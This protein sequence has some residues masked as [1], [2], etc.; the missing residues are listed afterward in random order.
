MF[1]VVPKNSDLILY[2]FDGVFYAAV[3]FGL[4]YWAVQ[5]DCVIKAQLLH[6][7]L[8]I[9]YLWSL[10]CLD[11]QLNILHPVVGQI[12]RHSF[13]HPLCFTTD[14]LIWYSV[15]PDTSMPV[16]ND[17]QMWRIAWQVPFSISPLAQ[18][19]VIH[20][21]VGGSHVISIRVWYHH[22]MLPFLWMFHSHCSG[23]C[24]MFATNH[25]RCVRGL[26]P[27]PFFFNH[28]R[29]RGYDWWIYHSQFLAVI[30]VLVHVLFP[31]FI[32][33]R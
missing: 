27:S 21:Y 28:L 22:Q 9:Y 12:L 30:K 7:R 16:V 32:F 6:R 14:S 11:V 13:R 15:C 25:V 31:L 18:I 24:A 17:N 19:H 33:I 2:A 8:Y 10:V 29:R 5:W 26:V 3:T 23:G 1:D 4:A 20:R